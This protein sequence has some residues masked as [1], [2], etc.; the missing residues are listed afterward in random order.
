MERAWPRWSKAAGEASGRDEFAGSGAGAVAGPRGD[1]PRRFSGRGRRLRRGRSSSTARRGISF[2]PRPGALFEWPAARGLARVRS[3]AQAQAGALGQPLFPR[4]KLGGVRPVPGG[5]ALSRKGLSAPR[6]PAPETRP[7]PRRAAMFDG[8]EPAG[9]RRGPARKARPRF[10]GRLGRVVL[11]QPH[12]FRPLDPRLG[13]L[14]GHCAGLT[15]RAPIECGSHGASGE[16]RRREGGVPQSIGDESAHAG[17]SLS[18]R[19]AALGRCFE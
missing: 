8:L 15:T 2:R 12:L 7:G 4:R 5:D 13:T 14:A 9:P 11:H 16:A 18:A 19:Q 1:D 6:R 10:S 17:N 3:G